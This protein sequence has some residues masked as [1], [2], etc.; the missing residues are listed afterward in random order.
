M[1]ASLL[2]DDAPRVEV[3]PSLN[4]DLAGL[5][6]LLFIIIAYHIQHPTLLFRAQ[7]GRSFRD[8]GL[9]EGIALALIVSALFLMGSWW[10]LWESRTAGR[11]RLKLVFAGMLGLFALHTFGSIYAN[12]RFFQDFYSAS[13]TVLEEVYKQGDLLPF[14]KASNTGAILAGVA[15]FSMLC[16]WSP[17]ERGHV[18]QGRVRLGEVVYDL[19]GLASLILIFLTYHI[20]NPLLLARTGIG[21]FLTSSETATARSPQFVAVMF[22]V[23]SSLL[24]FAPL[25][26]YK[27]NGVKAVKTAMMWAVCLY[28]FHILLVV[29]GNDNFLMTY[30]K[31]AP[32]SYEILITGDSSLVEAFLALDRAALFAGMAFAAA[33]YLWSPWEQ[34]DLYNNAIQQNLM[35]IGIALVTLVVWEGLIEV[36]NIKQFLLP[37]PSVIWATLL[38]EYPKMVA[39]GWFTFLN[40][41]KG[42]LIG[43]GAGILTGALSARF[44]K[45]STALLPL[46]IAA[47]SVPIIAFAPI[48][49]IWFDVTTSNPKIAIVAVMTYFPAMISTVR[50]LTSI[51]KTQLELMRSYA[52]SEWAVFQKLRLPSALPFIFSALKL[53][54]TLSMIG[55]IVSEFF[56]GSFSGLGYRIREDAVLFRFPESWSAIIVAS[57]FGIAFYLLVSALERAAMPWYSAFRRQS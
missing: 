36:L 21:D 38:E 7:F 53:A 54:T 34:T 10:A 49:N 24:V 11:G 14:M 15:L 18:Y 9:Q 4:R 19:A 44:T 25:L 51:D 46:A 33:L 2:P 31:V 1:S 22:L 26:R 20:Q 57:L 40:A 27:G 47:N 23:T 37:R 3:P 8:E 29:L 52:A 56:G 48:M 32:D 6:T 43:C 45:F 5:L 12:E 17:W 35:P 28:T 13:P 16:L 30:Y 55:A 39:A 42:F 41:F 50:G